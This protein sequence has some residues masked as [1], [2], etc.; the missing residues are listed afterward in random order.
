[1]LPF[2]VDVPNEQSYEYLLLALNC[3]WRVLVALQI[4]EIGFRFGVER[5]YRATV[6]HRNRTRGT[7]K[8]RRRKRIH[9]VDSVGRRLLKGTT[10]ETAGDRVTGRGGG[11]GEGD[12][13]ASI[14]RRSECQTRVTVSAHF[15]CI[16]INSTRNG[17]VARSSLWHLT[18]HSPRIFLVSTPPILLSHSY[19]AR[20]YPYAR[21]YVQ[22]FAV[23]ICFSVLVSFAT[24]IYG[25]C[26]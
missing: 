8:I 6:S 19:V 15:I 3:K 18:Y 1:M 26:F 13:F 7:N 16:L 21:L 2:G 4:E 14:W 23:Y 25:S 10:K 9:G 22:P 5:W 12:K 20:F 24:L 17:I 11:R